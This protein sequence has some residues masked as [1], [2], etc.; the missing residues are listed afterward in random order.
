[1]N[2]L[3]LAQL[4][5]APVHAPPQE[6]PRRAAVSGQR[7]RVV[8]ALRVSIADAVL[9]RSTQP[10][11]GEE[12]GRLR[13]NYTIPNVRL[14][15]PGCEQAL[16][17]FGNHT[18]LATE[19][20]L[21]MTALRFL[22]AI[23]TFLALAA[24]AFAQQPCSPLTPPGQPCTENAI[25][26]AVQQ[27]VDY[28]TA[29]RLRVGAIQNLKD[30]LAAC[31]NCSDRAQIE[32]N[33]N[34]L[35]K[36]DAAIR[37]MEG[38]ALRAM[39]F[40]P[41]VHDFQDLGKWL[42]DSLKDKPD[43][44][45]YLPI[46]VA[47]ASIITHC[48]VLHGSAAD[49]AKCIQEYDPDEIV[50]HRKAAMKYCFN[51]H[52]YFQSGSRQAYDACM[53]QNDVLTAFCTQDQRA[54][55]N[56]DVACPG[57][58]PS[59]REVQVLRYGGHDDL[60][61]DGARHIV[62]PFVV[63]FPEPLNF[64]KTKA[65]HSV[66]SMV[67]DQITDGPQIII[68]KGTEVFLIVSSEEQE[69]APGRF[70]AVIVGD[71]AVVGGQ[72]VTLPTRK[73]YYRLPFSSAVPFNMTLWYDSDPPVVPT[74]APGLPPG[75]AAVTTSPVSTQAFRSTASRSSLPDQS[76]SALATQPSALLVIA[77]GARLSVT[78]VDAIDLSGVEAGRKFR[79]R[80]ESP[81][82]SGNQIVLP[83][84]TEVYLKGRNLGSGGAP[85]MAHLSI[86]VD[87]VVG[88]DGKNITLTTNEFG[89]TIKTNSAVTDRLS[90]AINI[91]G[92]RIAIG[93]PNA[94][95]SVRGIDSQIAPQTQM[96]FMVAASATN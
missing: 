8:S 96:F 35:L 41:G 34:Q 64:V 65:A 23:V 25:R 44:N 75:L 85:N 14:S 30:K 45:V 94:G 20:G 40:P 16:R 37:S 51:N 54:R 52:D 42:A 87:Y 62:Q 5:H 6:G 1:M 4:F 50:K 10:V 57:P 18:D 27:I 80:L 17:I 11:R 21:L 3:D 76:S 78:T 61:A 48:R 92:R 67:V 86:S 73:T 95:S 69:N 79:A 29:T 15:A 53:N 31:G 90:D 12:F 82:R 74:V 83:E 56:S 89:K 58:V 81:V 49:A 46:E 33:L 36:E 2:R 28:N 22:S 72:R 13:F 43:V 26:S 55:G 71:Y 93:R 38:E 77:A 91:R 88:P 59:G 32:A 66:R 24:G 39:G 68:P 7:V 84:G 63:R 70:A 19:E 9:R 60:K 47:K